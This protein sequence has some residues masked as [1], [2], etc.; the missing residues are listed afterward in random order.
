[1]GIAKVWE[2]NKDAVNRIFPDAVIY[3]NIGREAYFSRSG[4][5][6][7][8]KFDS[9][10]A[11]FWDRT[12]SGYDEMLKFIKT[13]SPETKVF[14]LDDP[15]GKMSIEETRLLIKENIYPEISRILTEGRIV[16]DRQL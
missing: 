9:E 1:M 16:R 15:D 7:P 10:D 14:Q 12:I 6:N 2:A 5:D 13:L 3:L 8:D 4:G 11:K